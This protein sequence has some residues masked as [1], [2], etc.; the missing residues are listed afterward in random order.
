METEVMSAT[1]FERTLESRGVSRRTFLKFCGAI[2]ASIGLAETS[3][4]AVAEAIEEAASNKAMLPVIWLEQGSC[5]GCTES[6]AQVHTPDVGTILLELLSLNYSET[7][8]AGAGWSLEE[9]KEETIEE[10]GYLLIVE[11]SIMEGWDGQALRIAGE[12]GTDIVAHAA[13]NAIAVVAAGSCAVDGGW[14]AAYPNPAGATGVQ[15]LLNDRGIETPVIN[16]PTCPVNPE[17]IVSVIVDYLMLGRLPELDK[18]GFPTLIYGETIHDNCPRR[19][20]FE[21]GEFVYRFGTAEETKEYCL[22][23]VGCKGPQTY[24]NCPVT[25]WN[26]NASWCVGS[27]APCI[28]C[29]NATPLHAKRNWVQLNAPFLKRHRVLRIGNARIQPAA[30]AGTIT[31][32][33]AVAIVIHG[34]GMKAVGR[35][36]KGAEFEKA[37][38]WDVKHPDRALYP[39]TLE[40]DDSAGDTEKARK[41]NTEGGD[42]K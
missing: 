15:K 16:L 39:K 31:G 18:N 11:G 10:G 24:A 38:K 17:W 6:F 7:L 9:A 21:N 34:I 13:E 29:A 30:L 8:S 28:G 23:P 32:I 25:R 1:A 2:A 4:P 12:K 3:A 42:A 33:A 26:E 19:G 35:A 41:S 5:T 37:R 36:P 20:H 14:T 27:G 40:D 22:Y